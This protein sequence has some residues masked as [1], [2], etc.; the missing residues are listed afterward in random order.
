M[1][2]NLSYIGFVATLYIFISVFLLPFIAYYLGKK[3]TSTPVLCSVICFLSCLVPLLS[4]LFLMFLV[5]KDDY[6]I[7]VPEKS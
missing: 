1:N 4:L 3:K 5:L 2:I 6:I 7:P